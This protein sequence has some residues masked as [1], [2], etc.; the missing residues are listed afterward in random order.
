M[1]SGSSSRNVPSSN[2]YRSC[3]AATRDRTSASIWAGVNPEGNVEV[4]TMRR[5]RA[6]GGKSHSKLTPT[7][8]SPAP[9]A[10]RISV[11]EGS[12]DTIRTTP[13]YRPPVPLTWLQPVQRKAGFG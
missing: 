8:S 3:P 2:R 1:S 5:D 4:E 12:N 6:S 9:S 7:T 13:G 11:A 10:Y